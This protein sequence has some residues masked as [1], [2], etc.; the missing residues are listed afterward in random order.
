M[1]DCNWCER[2]LYVW[3]DPFSYF[4]SYRCTAKNPPNH[5]GQ[6]ESCKY[7]KQRSHR[8]PDIGYSGEHTLDKS[9]EYRKKHPELVYAWKIKK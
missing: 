2:N 9:I 7:Y 8:I 5:Q 1:I 6:I 4:D 3:D